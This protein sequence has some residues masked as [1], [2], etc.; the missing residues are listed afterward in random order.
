MDDFLISV[1]RN[2]NAFL[3]PSVAVN[4]N[5]DLVNANGWFDSGNGST[6]YIVNDGSPYH[7]NYEFFYGL[8]PGATGQLSSP[9][10]FDNPSEYASQVLDEAIAAADRQNQAAQ[11]SA[12]RAM[13][14]SERMYQR[15]MDF[16]SAEALAYREHQSAEAQ[17]NREF[18]A[19]QAQIARDEYRDLSNTQYQRAMADLKAAGLNPKLVGQLGGAPSSMSSAAAGSVAGGSA[20]SSSSPSGV[21]ANMS[22][23]NV[24]ALGNVLSTYISGADALDR[25]QND[26]VQNILT[27][28]AYVG[29]GLATKS[30]PYQYSTAFG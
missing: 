4:E 3:S 19:E 21:S 26:F 1:W 5:G 9:D 23:T 13:D 24:S 20:A 12:D 14:F 2:V 7:E 22:A 27:T 6:D 28:L 17:L 29:L 10:E 16:N 18:Q 25:N 15:E 30:T 11:T 8:E